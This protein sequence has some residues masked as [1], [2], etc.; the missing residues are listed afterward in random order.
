M[1]GDAVFGEF[2]EELV[3]RE[4]LFWGARRGDLDGTERH[5]DACGVQ[6]MRSVPVEVP[7]FRNAWMLP[8]GV[9]AKA[10]FSAMNVLPFGKHASR[11]EWRRPPVKG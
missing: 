5:L 6:V 9:L 2:G 8:R 3:H 1:E 4:G 11:R 7:M 10:P